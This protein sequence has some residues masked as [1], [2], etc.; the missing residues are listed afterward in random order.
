MEVVFMGTPDFAVPCLEALA[1]EET[2]KVKGV[3]TQPDKKKGRGQKVRMTPIKQA[4][5]ENDWEV[6]QPENINS[7]AAINKLADWAP[8]LI[9][10]VAYGQILGEQVL[11]LPDL[12]CVNVHASLLPK[13]RGA[14]PIHWA[15]IKGEEKTGITTMYMDEG[16]DTGD[17]ILKQEVEI[18]AEE[19][20]G[21]LHD[22]LAQGG[23]ELL[24]ETIKQIEAGT[25]PRQEQEDAAATYATKLDKEEC[26]VDWREP[27]EKVRNLIRGLNPWPG[28]YTYLDGGRLKLYR[29]EIYNNKDNQSVKPG[30]IVHTDTSEGIVVQTGNGQLLLTKLQ[31]AGKQKMAATDYLLGHELTAGIK[32]GN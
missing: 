15:I 6:F 20:A 25:A 1:A 32:L 30:T 8:E 3:I 31:P 27:V 10:V 28:A 17:M 7:E 12:G 5:V 11:N 9:V 29:S 19:T 18:T 22:K 24:I 16:M 23:S 13:Y 21:S 4:A 14:A 2:V 26:E